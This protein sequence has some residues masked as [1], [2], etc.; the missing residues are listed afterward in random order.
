MS[1]MFPIG[2]LT[3]TKAAED[4]ARKLFGELGYASRLAG[5]LTRHAKGDWGDLN[6][7]GKKTNDDALKAGG[8]LFSAYEI[9]PT[10]EFW[11]IT[12]GDRKVTRILLPTDY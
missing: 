7:N 1:A 9:T 2:R 3:I 4:E 11:I 5:L 10:S 12:E 6:A 8:R